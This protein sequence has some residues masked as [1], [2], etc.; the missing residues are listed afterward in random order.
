M[1]N[2]TIGV[3]VWLVVLGIVGYVATGMVSVTALIPAFFGAVL[4]GLGLMA[5][6]E[7]RR[8]TAMHLAMGL[9]LLGL[10][11]SI[12]GLA[13]AMQWLAGGEVERPAAALSRSLMAITLVVY[14]VLGVR[15]FIAARANRGA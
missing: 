8:R 7:G 13:P 3:G 6:A 14:L 4:A 2:L 9:A 1:A 15:S 5:R 10:L 11:G 12:G